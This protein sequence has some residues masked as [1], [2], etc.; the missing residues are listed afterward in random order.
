M[1]VN[2][3]TELGYKLATLTGQFTSD[4]PDNQESLESWLAE[5]PMLNVDQLL[6]QIPSYIQEMNQVDLTDKIR[7]KMLEMLRPIIAHICREIIKRFRK[8]KGLNLSLEFQ[9]MEWLINV[10]LREVSL[11]YQR[12]L[13][14]KAIKNPRFYNRSH[15]ALLAERVMYYL[16]ERITFVYMLHSVVPSSI[17]H[18]L[19]SSYRFA[20]KAE[21]D[22]I[23]TSDDFAFKQSMKCTIAIIYKRILLLTILSPQSLR[24]AEIEQIY[25]GML[26]LIDTIKLTTDISSSKER[27]IINWESD[28]GPNYSDTVNN[29][30]DN[31]S[32][33]KTEFINELTKWLNTGQAPILDVDEGISK[34]LLKKLISKLDGSMKRIDE[35]IPADGQQVEVV[36]GLKNIEAFLGHVEALKNDVDMPI[37]EIESDEFTINHHWNEKSTQG[38]WDAFS[39]NA[40]EAPKQDAEQ[41]VGVKESNK[42]IEERHYYFQIENESAAGVCLRCDNEQATDLV[43]GELLFILGRDLET[44]TLG[45]VRWITTENKKV[46]LGVYFLGG[47]VDCINVSLGNDSKNTRKALWLQEG[48]SGATVLLATTKFRPGDVINTQRRGID[49]TLILHEII[50]EN[51]VFSQFSFELINFETKTSE[52]DSTSTKH[53]QD[54][55]IP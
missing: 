55:L 30:A 32:I 50:W 10:L 41:K 15:Y 26:P 43:I 35:R 7:F 45:I 31:W 6:H 44:W 16:G 25:L 3:Q 37:Q 1:A 27:H 9:E 18:D 51:E 33:D 22:A 11:G 40:I 39:H 29:N 24:S 38:D 49:L 8:G 47:E 28:L 48:Q 13:F 46:D 42:S 54:Y 52:P 17:W 23:Q 34:K 5:R 36:I 21:L 14:N 4:L 19:N 2:G 20:R 53:E 12:L